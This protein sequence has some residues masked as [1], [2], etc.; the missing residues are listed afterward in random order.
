MKESITVLFTFSAAGDVCCPFIVYPYQRLPEKICESI[1]EGWGIG[2]SDN[3]WMTTEVFYEFIANVFHPYLV[4]KSVEFPV[5]LYVD[6]HK[7]HL[8]YHLSQLCTHLQ[9]ELI[10]LY[11]NATRIIQPA[12]VSAFRPLKMG[13]RKYLKKW[14]LSNQNK[15]IT[16]LNFA[17][18]LYEVVTA[19]LRPDILING[20]RTCGLCPFNPDSINYSKCLGKYTVIQPE[21]SKGNLD[22]ATITYET[23]RNITGVSLCK[24]F[25]N[26]S[27]NT[28]DKHLAI[29]YK[30]WREFQNNSQTTVT[31]VGTLENEANTSQ[32]LNFVDNTDKSQTILNPDSNNK[33]AEI[34]AGQIIYPVEVPPAELITIPSTSKTEHTPYYLH[35]LP[36]TSNCDQNIFLAGDSETQDFSEFQSDLVTP[37]SATILESR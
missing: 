2:K 12:D 7:T 17:P 13:W 33:I 3:G 5:I 30:L 11:P 23:F 37:D 10:A 20:F 15:G 32:S 19:S 25:E 9:I 36:G 6:G 8:N 34:D 1:P 35:S 16:K 31:S 14:Q 18:I 28:T 27:F 4:S 29:I 22:N 26:E 24:N 21:S